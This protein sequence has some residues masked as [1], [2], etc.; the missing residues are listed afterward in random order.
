MVSEGKENNRREEKRKG[1]GM[2]EIKI[3][4]KQNREDRGRET[5]RPT[6]FGPLRKT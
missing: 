3:S 2:A 6:Q 1:G 4:G 5:K